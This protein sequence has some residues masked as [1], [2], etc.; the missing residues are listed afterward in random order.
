MSNKLQTIL[1]VC[2]LPFFVVATQI[3]STWLFFLL[4]SVGL[5]FA[6]ATSALVNVGILLTVPKRSRALA[7]AVNTFTIHVLGDVISPY[8]VG[9]VHDSIVKN[10]GWAGNAILACFSWLFWTVLFWGMSWVYAR[11][12]VFPA[13]ASNNVL[14][15]LEEE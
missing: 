5:V 3:R 9:A 11:R 12:R 8:A 10:H 6:F 4:V 14:Q 13:P 7:V 2:S 15:R 1:I